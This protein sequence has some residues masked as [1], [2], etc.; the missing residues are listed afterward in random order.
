MLCCGDG[1]EIQ[2]SRS[3][4]REAHL[5]ETITDGLEAEWLGVDRRVGA[6]DVEHNARRGPVVSRPDNHAVLRSTP[7]SLQP[8]GNRIERTHADHEQQLPLVVVLE[9]RE[10][11]NAVPERLLALGVARDLANDEFVV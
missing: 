11:V 8:G 10:R 5:L 7:I 4:I 2:R 1:Y 9:A 3:R 6:E